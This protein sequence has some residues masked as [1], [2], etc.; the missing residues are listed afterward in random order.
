M[1][2]LVECLPTVQEAPGFIRS[3]YRGEKK[4]PKIALY[5]YK[6]KLPPKLLIGIMLGQ[7]QKRGDTL[8][9]VLVAI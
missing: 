1:T 7:L 4:N 5:P 9:L 8:A 6:P 3:T 2:Q